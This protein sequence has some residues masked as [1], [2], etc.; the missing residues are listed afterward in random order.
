MSLTGPGRPAG[1]GRHLYFPPCCT[2]MLVR[3]VSAV[4]VVEPESVVA[5]RVTVV[6]PTVVVVQFLFSG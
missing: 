2:R 5:L 1:S 3:V 4:T 6:S